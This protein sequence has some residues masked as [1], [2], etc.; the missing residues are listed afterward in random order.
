MLAQPHPAAHGDIFM[1]HEHDQY[2]DS[3]LQLEIHFASLGLSDEAQPLGGEMI[4]ANVAFPSGENV[5]FHH[6]GFFKGPQRFRDQYEEEPDLPMPDAVMRA[7]AAQSSGCAGQWSPRNLLLSELLARHNMESGVAATVKFP[8][9]GLQVRFGPAV[10]IAEAKTMVLVRKLLSPAVPVPEVYGW[11][12]AGGQ[13]FIYMEPPAPEG[14]TLASRWS[15]ISEEDRRA[16]CGELRN[17]ITTWR[18]LKQPDGVN[19]F[20]GSVDFSPL[21]DEI[22]AS[23]KQTAPT[24]PGPFPNVAT[25]HS[26]IATAIGSSASLEGRNHPAEE[27][28]CHVQQRDAVDSAPI[29]FTHANLHPGSVMV[30]PA[31]SRPRVLSILDWDQAGWYPVYWEHAKALWAAS[32][33]EREGWDARYL[34]RV[35][36]GI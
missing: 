27:L 21:R 16:I 19:A 13:N 8:W 25:L 11:R 14:V 10:S 3:Q 2:D 7:N 22:F 31:P 18:R 17:M 12:R 28:I 1:Q 23:E 9:L 33:P 15:T 34:S 36:E 35:F 32:S 26:W 24:S 4:V 20:I 30:S 5:V 29:M 6:S